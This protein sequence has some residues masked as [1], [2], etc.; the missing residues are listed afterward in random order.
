MWKV[1]QDDCNMIICKY[2]IQNIDNN[3]TALMHLTNPI[4]VIV[5]VRV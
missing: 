3:L 4:M 2:V 1:A 5:I